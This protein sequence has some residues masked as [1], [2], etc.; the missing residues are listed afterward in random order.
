VYCYVPNVVRAIREAARVL[1]KGGRLVVLD[2]DWDMC[3]WASGDPI[4]TRRIITA[5]GKS[6]FAHAYLPREVHRLM[7]DAGL[8]LAGA[9]AFSIIETRFD[10]ES[11][12]VGIIASTRQA[13]L[14]QGVSEE[15]VIRWE[16]DLRSRTSDGD[17]F[18]C[19]DRFV[20]TGIKQS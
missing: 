17:W 6:Q 8:A 4:L 16:G 13:A 12:S 2:S 7:Q 1:R 14:K 3:I 5:R 18:F 9:Q 15:D 10:P 19:L 11:F 20:F